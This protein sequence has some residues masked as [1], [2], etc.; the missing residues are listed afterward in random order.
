MARELAS[1]PQT[2]PRRPE[3]SGTARSSK[4][5]V[6]DK[7]SLSLEGDVLAEALQRYLPYLEALSQAAIPD[8]FPGLKPDRPPAQ[9]ED[10][11]ADSVLTFVARTSALTYAPASRA[12][13]PG[14]R[15]LRTLRRLQPD[16]LSPKVAGGADRQ[17]LVAALGAY[18]ARKPPAPPRDGDPAT[19]KLVR[20]PWQEPR[21]LSAPA[22]P[23]K[24]PSPP[25]PRDALGTD[26][27]ARV[28]ALLKDLRER[29]GSVEGLSALDVAEAARAI[30]SAMPG[31]RAEGEQ[32]GAGR[33]GGGPRGQA[34]RSGAAR[35]RDGVPDNR[36]RDSGAGFYQE[37]SSLGVK[38]GDLLQG[39]GSPFLPGA[40]HLAGSFKTEIKKS[41]DPEASPSSEEDRVG[42]ENIKSQTYSKELLQ[43]PPHP[44][45]GPGGLGA[46]QLRAPAAPQE[47]QH[48]GAGARGPPGQGLRLEVQPPQEEYGYIVTENDPLSP[49]KGTEVLEDVARLLDMPAGI[50][51]DIAVS[52]PTV[53]FRVR[54]NLQNVT[55]ADAAKAAGE[56]ASAQAHAPARAGEG[57]Q[58]LRGQPSPQS[59]D[60]HRVGPG[61]EWLASRGWGVVTALLARIEGGVGAG[62]RP[63]R[64]ARVDKTMPWCFEVFRPV[65]AQQL[66]RASPCPP[67]PREHGTK[68]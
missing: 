64:R 27:G 42:V 10:P 41:E 12:D 67:G 15:P 66:A 45:P 55:A 40:P 34:G 59:P 35:H 52:G 24:W 5:S 18:A 58:L 2:S 23:Q 53:T 22:A 8:V 14:D 11:P 4:Q 6:Q 37:V 61:G 38:L 17:S 16:E 50:F 30:A 56:A 57:G 48:P 43:R 32:D 31:G 28:Q 54:A 51:S 46:S 1:L 65:P 21:V 3:A 7:R 49:E 26:D 29:P 63:L 44:E 68:V 36:V 39:P 47:D 20:A 19:R 9:G 60:T 33:G 13:F 62:L 25:D